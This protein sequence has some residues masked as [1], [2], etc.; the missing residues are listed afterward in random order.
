MLKKQNI[1]F[2]FL[3]IVIMALPS[4][5][6]LLKPGYFSMHDD[7]QVMRQFQMEKCLLDGQFPCRWSPDMGKEYG[8]PM[9]N[10]YSVFPYYFGM[11][12]RLFGISF[13]VTVKIMFGLSIIL[14]GFFMYLLSKE[15]LSKT[16]AIVSTIL[17]IY[18]PYRAVDVFVRGALSESWGITFFPIIFYFIWKLIKEKK[19]SWFLGLIIS[20]CFLFQTHNITTLTFT[21]LAFCWAIFCAYKLKKYQNLKYFIFSFV[22]AILLSSFFLIPAFLEKNLVNIDALKSGYYDF[23]NH[24]A[25]KSQLFTLRFWGYGSSA[26]VNSNMSFQIGWPH[27]WLLFG[28]FIQLIISKFIKTKHKK[29]ISTIGF[30]I[31]FTL[32]YT[33]LIHQ[34]SLFIW[35]TLPLMNFIQFP[36]RLLGI[37]VFCISIVGGFFIDF[38]DFVNKKIK[39]IILFLIIILAIAFN[40]SYFRPER[41]SPKMTD[42]E[43]LSGIEWERQT[44]GAFEDYL[45]ITAKTPPTENAPSQPWF[46]E[47]NAGVISQ[48]RKRSNFWRFTVE[49]NEDNQ[50]IIIPIFD[51]P[52]WEILANNAKLDSQYNENG[53]IE[54]SLNKGKYTVVGWFRN[55]KTRDIANTLSILSFMGLIFYLFYKSNKNE[56]NL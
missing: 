53:L 48:Y 37:V 40:F 11:F 22:W 16:G 5:W 15:F 19:T 18:A 52:N 30:F 39:N 32:I 50:K 24:F 4:V 56:E 33:F 13:I 41:Y 29:D 20:F 35:E 34:R 17:F 8:Q 36:W 10:Y 2:I 14:S 49:V 25:N 42:Q 1:I 23:R 31:F 3:A 55:T 27:W 44:N 38:F 54:I 7:L 43:K 26:G 46:E 45:P 28:L 47:N 9:F 51:F 12:F 21:P 6:N